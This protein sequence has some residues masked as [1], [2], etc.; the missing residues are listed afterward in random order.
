MQLSVILKNIEKDDIETLYEVVNKKKSPQTGIAS[1]EKI[2][3]FY[4]LFKREYRQKHTDKTLH[5][6]YVSLTQE[7]ERIAEMLD[8]HLRALYEDNESP[9]KNKASEMVSHLHL[10]INC[11]LDLA[12]TYDKKYPE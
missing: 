8:L 4:N 9:Y 5:H 2:K 1:M 11:I 3:T 10:H 12:Q 7:F 6:S